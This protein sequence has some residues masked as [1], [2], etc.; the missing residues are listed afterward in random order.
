MAV[1]RTGRLVADEQMKSADMGALVH[2]MVGR[3]LKPLD[4]Y[5]PELH[6]LFLSR[7]PAGCV[8]DG[9]IVIA[10]Q[11]GLDFEALQ[12]RIHPAASRVALLAEAI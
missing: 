1:L 10:T 7:L 2:A 5:F 11:N 9:E 6:D 12:Q 8:L 4:R 3:E